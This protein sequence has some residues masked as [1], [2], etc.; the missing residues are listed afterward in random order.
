MET[1]VRV[2]G[3][4][5]AYADGAWLP[6]TPTRPHAALAYLAVRGGLV[7]RAELAALL[8][9]DAD[10]QSAHAGLR[11]VLMRLDRGPFGA[12]IGRDRSGLWLDGD[13]DVSAFR[14]A[15]AEGGWAEAVAMHAG[16]LLHGFEIDDADEY[17]AW[18]ASERAAVAEDW[19]RACRALMTAAS[20][21]GRHGDAECH[22]DL[23]VRADPLDEQAVREAMRAAAAMGDQ[24]GVAR[25][26]RALTALL[27]QETGLAPEA[28]TQELW[29]RL[30]SAGGARVGAMPERLPP[31]V[32]VRAAGERRGVVG[33]EDAIADLVWRLGQR[34]T[35]LVTLLGPGGIGKTTLAAAL[36]AELRADSS[37]GARIVSLE[38][39]QG[40]DAVALAIAQAFDVELTPGAVPARQLARALDG[41]RSLVVLD[42][43]ELHLD[44]LSTVDELL[45]G[46]SDLRLLVT[47]RVRLRHSLEV[48][49]EV[50][51]LATRGTALCVEGATLDA[52]VS[53]AAQLFLR[54]AA[55]RL[56]LRAVRRLELEAVERVVDG[57]GGHPLAIEIAASWVDV[58]G[59]EGLEAQVQASWV[60]L[61][62]E[63]LDR[64]ARRRDVRAV[65]REAWEGL[66]AD[67][68]SA[69]ARLA[70]MPGSV[71]LAVAAE[72]CGSGWRGLRGLLD[73]AVLR[74]D[75][76]RVALHPLLARFGR[77]RARAAG[78]EDAAWGAAV[79]VWRSRLA[80]QVDPRSGRRV[81]LHADDLEQSLGAW[82]WAV[83]ACDWAAL[84]D[85]AVGLW[86]ALDE[87]MRWREAAVLSRE[88]VE[89]LRAARGRDRDVALARLWPE[90][91]RT[92][93]ERKSL[94]ARALALAAA[95]G[96]DLAAAEA[97]AWLARGT[98]TPDRAVH[99][100]AA[101][102]AFERAGD[103]V[104][105]AR[106]LVAQGG[107]SVLA[108]RQAH[109]T[110]L[111]EEAHERCER[112]ADAGGLALVH[113]KRGRLALHRGDLAAAHAEMQA[114]RRLIAHGGAVLAPGFILEVEAEIALVAADPDPA[115]EAIGAYIRTLSERADASYDELVMRTGFHLRF[116]PA[117]RLLEVA[118]A[119]AS[120]METLGGRLIHRMLVNLCLALAHARL[121]APARAAAP[122]ALA[123]G[124]AR[125]LEVPRVVAAIAHTA[126]AV[127]AAR[128]ERDAAR[129]LLGLA[130]R[131]PSL[132]YALRLDAEALRVSLADG[133]ALTDV[134]PIGEGA[135]CDD[136]AILDEVEGWLGGWV[137]AGEGLPP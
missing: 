48:V 13:S 38:G 34:E 91:G 86:R 96:D 74:H 64:P 2:L 122:L 3:A 73:R 31:P 120:H 132:E 94:A 126:A 97:H 18:L 33:R 67:D 65:V 119:W 12:R 113:A 16:P 106:L 137:D 30:T 54:T 70:V 53:P 61:H 105:L 128:G 26:Y 83:A 125:P 44:Q 111:L 76:E 135:L 41:R 1:G 57:L 130:L 118:G 23:L 88:A 116:G 129:R 58:M 60:P 85:M 7:R 109:A 20:A 77:E 24:R 115:T 35:R 52:N 22:A 127:G 36:V 112:L 6:L 131:H 107:A 81:R 56:P 4:P 66:A 102:A 133:G 134:D 72:V 17:A 93:F 39:A 69:W 78:L 32:D 14:R 42:G 9:P 62:S 79:R 27:E 63:D 136:A 37:G 121:G 28:E 45:R 49:V 89:R 11:Q 92:L 10:T 95:C 55:A 104:G 46:T 19:G 71:D 5:E 90:V 40:P 80:Q 51:P 100:E 87:R 15:I 84:A 103:A 75:G 124:L 82:R 25:R 110:S 8:W 99:V 59:L 50:D 68:R 101:R 108:G 117:D 43:F 21:E 98:F 29:G 123:I 114:A 47:S